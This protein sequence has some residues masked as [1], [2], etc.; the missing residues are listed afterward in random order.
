MARFYG[1]KGAAPREFTGFT[2]PVNF[3]R[4]AGDAD[5]AA[6]GGWG[7]EDANWDWGDENADRADGVAGGG[8]VAGFGPRPTGEAATRAGGRAGSIRSPL[9]PHAVVAGRS[10]GRPAVGAQEDLDLHD[11]GSGGGRGA[12]GDR[13]GDGGAGGTRTIPVG[14]LSSG[15]WVERRVARRGGVRRY[16][17]RTEQTAAVG[18]AARTEP[19]RVSRTEAWLSS[20][21]RSLRHRLREMR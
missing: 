1:A 16:A 20:L 17:A 21:S 2:V 7:D 11:E 8:G 6:G 9:G 5:G 15:G 3:G 18:N 19:S 4:G 14:P 10:G 12:G 13:G